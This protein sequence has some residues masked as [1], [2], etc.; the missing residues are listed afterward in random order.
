MAPGKHAVRVGV[1]VQKASKPLRVES[2]ALEIDV[3][4][5]AT[6]PSGPPQRRGSGA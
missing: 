6:A 5:A 4:P 2:S 3:L 1:T